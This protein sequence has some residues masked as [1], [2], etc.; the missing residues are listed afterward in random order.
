MTT[1]LPSSPSHMNTLLPAPTASRD[2]WTVRIGGF[3]AL[4]PAEVLTRVIAGGVAV[5]F[6]GKRCWVQAVPSEPR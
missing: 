5:V 3:F 2:G 4:S 6:D 1:D